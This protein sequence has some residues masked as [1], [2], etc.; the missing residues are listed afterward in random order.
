M[1]I[2]KTHLKS[3]ELLTK[4]LLFKSSL[5]TS[6]RGLEDQEEI[7]TADSSKSLM[8]KVG[9]VYVIDN[10]KEFKEA[11]S[12][13]N[14]L[15][16][17][18]IN[19]EEV[20]TSRKIDSDKRKAVMEALVGR[21]GSMTAKNTWNRISD[22]QQSPLS[23]DKEVTDTARDVLNTLSETAQNYDGTSDEKADNEADF[24]KNLADVVESMGLKKDQLM[25]TNELT[26]RVK[27]LEQ[28][29][30]LTQT[31]LGLLKSQVNHIEALEK[32][33]EEKGSRIKQL[34]LTAKKGSLVSTIIGA[35]SLGFTAVGAT[36][37]LLSIGLAGY[38]TQ[39]IL[40]GLQIFENKHKDRLKTI[41]LQKDLIQKGTVTLTKGQF[42]YE[43]KTT[44]P[45]RVQ[46]NAIID[47]RVVKSEQGEIAPRN[48]VVSGNV[49]EKTVVSL[50]MVDTDGQEKHATQAVLEKKLEKQQGK[51]DRV[52][53]MLSAHS[54]DIS[55][56]KS[57]FDTN[58]MA[59]EAKVKDAKSIMSDM[60]QQ[61]AL[62]QMRVNNKE[63]GAEAERTNAKKAMDEAQK[64]MD[65][66]TEAMK[67]LERVQRVYGLNEKYAKQPVPAGVLKSLY[68]QTVNP[69]AL[70]LMLELQAKEEAKKLQE[71]QK[72]KEAQET[73]RGI[74]KKKMKEFLAGFE[75]DS[76]GRQLMDLLEDLKNL[77]ELSEKE[78]LI[79]H[80]LLKE[81]Q[82]SNKEIYKYLM[83]ITQVP[84]GTS[85]A[86]PKAAKKSE[87]P[88]EFIGELAGE[89]QAKRKTQE[90]EQNK[91]QELQG[92]QTESTQ[93]SS[94]SQKIESL[95]EV[96]QILADAMNANAS[97][98]LIPAGELNVPESLQQDLNRSAGDAATSTGS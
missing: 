49:A 1:N 91:T 32:T 65:R 18:N 80:P 48:A 66:A 68:E 88:I 8:E 63:D 50:P 38:L 67:A 43:F 71:K 3:Q 60:T 25:R 27:T 37:N 41:S 79:K 97:A 59:L 76:E 35:T 84:V 40:P 45:F 95:Q 89:L 28:A 19:L 16:G 94:L 85:Y 14:E 22:L 30:N 34:W 74:D 69:E 98:S 11:F 23:A 5:N 81:I 29:R 21:M 93:I 47:G 15:E 72:V 2:K 70:E 73:I 55:A 87:G 83:A 52:V 62:A 31:R 13:L 33:A 42:L 24:Y 53:N 92:Q 7:K 90:A 86:Q 6:N 78:I 54:S 44:T 57:S 51:L 77:R 46:K 61:M 82:N 17:V 12:F 36:A 39:R 56:M 10:P 75:D 64:V 96:V 4:R 9:Q 20:V 58:F 26:G